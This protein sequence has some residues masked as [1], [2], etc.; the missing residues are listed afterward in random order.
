MSR[1]RTHI[2]CGCGQE[3]LAQQLSWALVGRNLVLVVLL[4]PPLAA[5]LPA[6]LS[7]VWAGAAAGL[8][9]FLLYLL[10]NLLDAL[11]RAR[12]FA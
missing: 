9:F 5:P 11:P 8:G 6:A 3:F 7:E 12:R 10:F 4:V 2:D 1:G